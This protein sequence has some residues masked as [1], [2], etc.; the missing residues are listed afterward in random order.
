M[1][2]ADRVWPCRLDQFGHIQPKSLKTNSGQDCG[3][4]F[5]PADMFHFSRQVS[6]G[7]YRVTLRLYGRDSSAHCTVWA[8]ARRLMIASL[9]IFPEEVREVSFIVNV[10]TPTLSPPHPNAPKVAAVRLASEE[11]SSPDWDGALTVDVAECGALVTGVTVEPVHVPTIYLVGD[12]TVADEWQGS[13]A[14]WGQML[15]RFFKPDVAIANHARSGA[16]LKSFV[17]E[18]RLDKVLS[19][20]A[21]GDWLVIQFGHND[22]K[23]EWPK[24]YLEAATTYR[25]YLRTYI[26]ETRRRGAIPVLVTSPERRN[27]GANG[28]IVD[29]LGDYA[30]AVRAVAR[31]DSVALI[32]LN[33][34]SKTFYEALGAKQARRAF[35]DNGRDKTHHSIYGAYELARMM[36]TGIRAADPALLG[37]LVNHLGSDA[38]AFNPRAPWGDV[39]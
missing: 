8:E 4:G 28:R 15:P 1:W 32:D 20:L 19:T 26:A 21:T 37:D 39:H 34:M 5:V 24:T 11:I 22:Q 36:I 2:P 23:K 6:D 12:S 27:F 25:A 17:A 13:G 14:S 35:R 10:R 9:P 38:E 18:L 31:E 3:A 30:D 33:T 29:S 16:S 7:N